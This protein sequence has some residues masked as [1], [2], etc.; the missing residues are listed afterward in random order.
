ME[1][2]T[3]KMSANKIGLMP[4]DFKSLN[5]MVVPTKN[6]VKTNSRLERSTMLSPMNAGMF[7]KLFKTITPI[8]IRIKLMLLG[9]FRILK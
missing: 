9:M 6:K 5:L 3:H 7:T 1:M 4:M 2:E 8:K